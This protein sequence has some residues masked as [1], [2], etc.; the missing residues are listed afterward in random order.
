MV[1]LRKTV[2]VQRNAWKKKRFIEACE[3]NNKNIPH[4]RNTKIQSVIYKRE[5]HKISKQ[6]EIIT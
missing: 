3:Q 6:S 2:T 5:K 1:F 4:L